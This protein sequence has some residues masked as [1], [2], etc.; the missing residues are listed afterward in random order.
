MTLTKQT[1]IVAA[2]NLAAQRARILTYLRE[3]QTLTTL[4]ARSEL[5]VMHPAGRVQELREEGFNIVTHWRTDYTPEGKPHRVAEYVLMTGKQQT[6]V[7]AGVQGDLS[8]DTGEY[9]H[10]C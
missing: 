3:Y 7:A 4:Q 1:S 6:P 10:D 8:N 9:A 2:N 5:D